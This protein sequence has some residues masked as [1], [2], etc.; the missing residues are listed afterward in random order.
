M[1]S[2]VLSIKIEYSSIK[3]YML[4]KKLVHLIFTLMIHNQ[5]KQMI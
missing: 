4:T 3:V 1:E 5:K 2:G